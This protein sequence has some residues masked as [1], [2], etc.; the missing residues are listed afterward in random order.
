[1]GKGEAVKE[2]LKKATEWVKQHPGE[3][4]EIGEGITNFF[5][6]L[7][8]KKTKDE[9]ALPDANQLTVEQR[10]DNIQN[11]IQSLRVELEESNKVLE[12]SANE[13][14]QRIEGLETGVKN[15]VVAVE[16][17]YQSTNR[18]LIMLGVFSAVGIVAAVVLAILL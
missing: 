1:M 3:T 15:I 2:T 12:D 8:R 16:E 11:D 13:L 14:S 18:K 5:R 17:I 9:V 10:I 4:L 7:K 6:K